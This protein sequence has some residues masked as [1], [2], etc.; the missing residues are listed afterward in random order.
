V[1]P[2]APYFDQSGRPTVDI[3]VSN[4]IGWKQP[5][6][7]LID[8]G[9]D[10]FLMLPI[11]QAFPIGLLLRGTMSITLADGSGQDKLYCLGGI[12]YDG[13]DEVGIVIIEPNSNMAL[14]G[15]EFLRAFKRRLEVDPA[16]GTVAL[17][18]TQAVLPPSSGT[19]PT[20]PPTPSNP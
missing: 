19:P 14:L 16:A 18:R 17:I 11:A 15:M 6:T 10:G 8:T 2:T 12:E 7:A 5:V 9:F 1:A 3:E 4:P 13:E 20:V